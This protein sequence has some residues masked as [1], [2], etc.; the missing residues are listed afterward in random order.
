MV[1]KV[2]VVVVVEIIAVEATGRDFVAAE[3]IDNNFVAVEATD[4]GFVAV[5]AADRVVE[6]AS[7]EIILIF[8][9]TNRSQTYFV[10][11]NQLP[12]ERCK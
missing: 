9:K 8:S 2:V 10:A 12:S 4:K 5:E 3:V 1:D 11:G 7:K 6:V